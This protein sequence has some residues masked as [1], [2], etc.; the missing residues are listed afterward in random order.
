MS[1]ENDGLTVNG[2]V[3]GLIRDIIKDFK[4]DS[5][6]KEQLQSVAQYVETR[7]KDKKRSHRY[8]ATVDESQHFYTPPA[9][10][11]PVI[12]KLHEM[13][14]S[15]VW[16]PFAGGGNISN[17]LIDDGFDVVSTDIIGGTDILSSEVPAGV[18]AIVSNPEYG[19]KDKYILRAYQMG[20]PF[21]FLLP[22][23]SIGGVSR[24]S[25]YVKYG[26]HFI[27]VGKR[28]AFQTPMQGLGFG[29]V[30][31]TPNFGTMWVC[32]N[33]KSG[34]AETTIEFVKLSR[35]DMPKDCVVPRLSGGGTVRTQFTIEDFLQ[36]DEMGDL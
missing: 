18:Q 32:G 25:Y 10:L 30:E 17:V 6:T 35:Y 1:T 21:F 28:I 11:E 13:G 2:R 15:R 33:L 19:N 27:L 34:S 12:K 22:E 23:S 8:R 16:E 26:V 24:N 4:G 7:E 20:L 5:A 3:S 31:S 9:A 29:S 36:E 14:I